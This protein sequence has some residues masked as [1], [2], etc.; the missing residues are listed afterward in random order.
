MT[1]P[2]LPPFPLPSIWR[3]VAVACCPPAAT[4]DAAAWEEVERLAGDA[5]AQRPAAVVA[6]ARWFLTALPW[7]SLV[8]AG[9]PFGSLRPARQVAVLRRLERSPVPAFR[10]GVWGLRTL[11]FLGVYGRPA[12]RDALGWRPD[13]RG[14]DGRVPADLVRPTP[15]KGAPALR[16]VP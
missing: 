7:L 10:R 16:L 13:A 15:A 5:L 3:Q 1:L 12:M 2:A 9:R 14:W 11:A 4:L 6:Q 8:L